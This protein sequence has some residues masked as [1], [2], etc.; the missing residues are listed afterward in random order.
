MHGNGCDCVKLTSVADTAFM[1]WKKSFLAFGFF[2]VIPAYFL[3]TPI[4]DGY[5]TM[6]ACKMQFAL[7]TMKTVGGLV[8]TLLESVCGV[9]K[10]CITYQ[11]IMAALWNYGIGQAI[12][13]LPCDLYLLLYGHPME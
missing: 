11:F 13:F 8:G 5:S 10:I 12:I 1:G 7:A 9:L 3:Y 2:I 4:P 6:S